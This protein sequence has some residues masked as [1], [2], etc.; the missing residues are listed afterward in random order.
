MFIPDSVPFV[1]FVRVERMLV[2]GAARLMASLGE[3]ESLFENYDGCC[4]EEFWLWPR[5]RGRS[6]PA[7]GCKD[8]A[9]AGHGQKARRPEG[10]RAKGRLASLLLS[11]RSTRDILFRRASPS[12]L[13]IENSAPRSF[14]TGSKPRQE[15]ACLLSLSWVKGP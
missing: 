2:S 11:R 15:F 8:R 9:N 3:F 12:S 1:P 13:F 5:R 6:I 14:Q 7:A 10:L 4:G